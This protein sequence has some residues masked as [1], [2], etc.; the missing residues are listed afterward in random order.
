MSGT[1]WKVRPLFYW[2]LTLVHDLSQYQ[3]TGRATVTLDVTEVMFICKL[4]DR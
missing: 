3:L 1:E 2:D 4:Q